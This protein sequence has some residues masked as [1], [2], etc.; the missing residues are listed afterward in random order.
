MPRTSAFDDTLVGLT[1]PSIVIA[2]GVHG[3]RA[4][5]RTQRHVQRILGSLGIRVIVADDLG[6]ASRLIERAAPVLVVLDGRAASAP[7]IEQLVL[8]ARACGTQPCMTLDAG[9]LAQLPRILALGAVLHLLVHPM[10]ALGDALAITAHKLIR[11]DLFGAEKYLLWGTE[12]H[13]ATLTR[14]S[15][16]LHIVGELAEQA[17]A[18]GQSARVASTA[19]LVA[20]ELLSNAVHH[21]PVDDLGVH[22]RAELARDRELELDARHEVGL[23]WG[24]D[25]RYL[26]VEVTDKFGSLTCDPALRALVQKDVQGSGCGAGMGIAL[27]YRSCDHL[28]FNLAPGRRTQ[29]IALVDVR[30]SQGERVAAGSYNV[31]VER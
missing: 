14:A 11:G 23:R 28:V 26:A 3:A 2:H 15:Q 20:D 5:H 29:V 17:R 6:E 19:M 9:D 31:F 24:C 25:G 7:G 13:A 21:A 27:T 18:R 16:R 12:L 30:H 22:Y 1:A 8:A 10:P 4:E